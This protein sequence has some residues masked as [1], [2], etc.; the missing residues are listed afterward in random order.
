MS[1]RHRSNDQAPPPRADFRAHAHNERHRV[2][3]EL[4]LATEA[5]RNGTEPL[6]VVEP[7]SAWKP[8]HHH[9]PGKGAEKSRRPRLRH[10]KTKAW[11]RRSA[12]RK[13]RARAW[14][15]LA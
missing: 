8:D 9:D 7:G 10:W 15:E 14:D 4:H 12:N 11:K 5:V 13:A 6:D 2:H 3:S 1:S